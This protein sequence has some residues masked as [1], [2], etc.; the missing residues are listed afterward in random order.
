MNVGELSGLSWLNKEQDLK[1]PSLCAYS[2]QGFLSSLRVHQSA[3]CVSACTSNKTV[4]PTTLHKTFGSPL[5][6]TQACPTLH[7]T[8]G[9]APLH[10]GSPTILC[11]GH[12]LNLVTWGVIRSSGIIFRDAVCLLGLLALYQELF[13][14]L[15][16]QQERW[17]MRT[18]SVQQLNYILV[19]HLT[20]GGRTWCHIHSDS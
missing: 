12:L 19:C 10:S 13:I 7:K 17:S 9:S 4:F 6:F 1:L 15:K 16:V 8:V 20:S 11:Q 2:Q 3:S 14:I 5:L 18:G